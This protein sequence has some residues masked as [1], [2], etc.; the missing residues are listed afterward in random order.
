[1]GRERTQLQVVLAQLQR[2]SGFTGTWQVIQANQQGTG[3]RVSFTL[4]QDGVQVEAAPE[5]RALLTSIHQDFGVIPA[6]HLVGDGA[7]PYDAEAA[8]GA[9]AAVNFPDTGYDV[10]DGFVYPEWDYQ[11]LRFRENFCMLTEHD[12]EPVY[13]GFAAATVRKHQGALK[14]IRRAFEALAGTSDLHRRQNFGNEV[15]LDALVAARVDALQG[16]EMP[17][18]LY[19]HYRETRRDVALMFMVDMS[20]S[21]RGWVNRAEKESLVLLCEALQS[22]HDRHAIYGFS[23]R[24]HKRC[25]VYRIKDFDDPCGAVVRARISGIQPRTYTRMGVALRHLGGKLLREA[26][27]TRVLI[28]LSD[29]KPEDYGSYRGRYGI[30]DTRHALAELRRAGLH[31]FCITIDRAGGDYLPHMYGAANYTLVDD[32]RRLPLKVSDIYRRLTCR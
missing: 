18:G 23:G 27:A 4:L 20:G 31:C 3:Q 10:V 32:V 14:S 26:A 28:T 5:L 19:T 21:T 7:A 11:R 12:V 22:L 1:M 29:G 24:T 6:G 25:E 16:L 15:D 8:G 9:G 17:E 2:Q 30:E 13:D